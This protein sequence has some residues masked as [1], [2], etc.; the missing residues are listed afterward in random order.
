MGWHSAIF[1]PPDASVQWQPDGLT[2]CTKSG[3]LGAGFLGAP[4]ISLS[5]FMER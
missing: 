5:L 3:S 4:P 1:F 2:I